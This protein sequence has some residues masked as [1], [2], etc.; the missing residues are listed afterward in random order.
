[1]CIS[2]SDERKRN[3]F[4]C[5]T[6]V[7]AVEIQCNKLKTFVFLILDFNTFL[8]L[9]R[10]SLKTTS[11]RD[12]CFLLKDCFIYLLFLLGLAT[13]IV[14]SV[15]S[16]MSHMIMRLLSLLCITVLVCVGTTCL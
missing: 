6:S 8:F 4:F 10:T 14:L 5:S 9:W 15:L 3:H 13:V 1:M 12:G 11:L 2:G 7:T 16:G